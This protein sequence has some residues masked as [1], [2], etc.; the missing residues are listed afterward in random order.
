MVFGDRC[1]PVQQVAMSVGVSFGSVRTALTEILRMFPRYLTL[2]DKLKRSRTL[3]IHQQV[4][5]DSKQIVEIL[6]FFTS[7]WQR[8]LTSGRFLKLFFCNSEGVIK[9]DYL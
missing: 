5:K 8:L 7:S 2:E 3:V 9:I 6:W 4:S 1:I